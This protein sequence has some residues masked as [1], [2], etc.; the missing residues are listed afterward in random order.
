MPIGPQVIFSV[1]S[2]PSSWT[3]RALE[4]P[5]KLW[6]LGKKKAAKHVSDARVFAS[7]LFPAVVSHV[8]LF[9]IINDIQSIDWGGDDKCLT[10]S[11]FR[12][13]DCWSLSRK[14]RKRRD[15][16]ED[17]RCPKSVHAQH[18]FFSSVMKHKIPS[19]SFHILYWGNTW[20]RCLERPRTTPPVMFE[21]TKKNKEMDYEDNDGDFGRCLCI[22]DNCF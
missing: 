22:P 18:P 1:D 17:E 9:W 2:S 16:K 20:G 3:R 4:I 10:Y 8:K 15:R 11:S 13:R 7:F 21:E 6:L 14:T 5:D 12:K 19:S